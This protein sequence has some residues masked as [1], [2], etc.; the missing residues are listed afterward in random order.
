MGCIVELDRINNY[1]TG[2]EYTNTG[3]IVVPKGADPSK[4][5]NG[6]ITNSVMNKLHLIKLADDFP[7]MEKDI[8]SNR[9]KF[10]ALSFVDLCKM[11]TRAMRYD[12][13]DFLYCK[14][15]GFPVNRLITLRRYPYPCTDNIWDKESQGEPDI[16]RMVTYFDQEVNKMEELLGFGFKMKWKE[17]TAEYEQSTMQGD[18]AGLSGF[19]KKAFTVFDPN[20]YNNHLMG[21]N[22][23]M[24]DPKFDQ[25]KVYGPVDSIT[26]TNIRDVGLEFEKNFD[27]QFDYEL[28]SENGRTPE[29]AMKDILA[30]ILAC[31]FNDGK[32]WPGARYWVGDRPSQFY[33]RFQYMN[34]TDMDNILSKATNDLKSVLKTFGDK[35]SAV[36]ALKTAMQGGMA[37]AMG[38]ILDKVGRPGILTMNSLLSGEPTG[39]WHLTIGNPVN[40]IM[41]IGNLILE[42]VEV[43]FPTDALGYGDFPTKMRAKV[44]LKPAQ[45]RGRAGIEMP[46][47]MGKHRIYFAPKSVNVV[48][49]NKNASRDAFSFFGF[50]KKEVDNAIGQTYDFIADGVKSISASVVQKDKPVTRSGSSSSPDSSSATNMSG[51]ANPAFK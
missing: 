2:P 36:D 37:L 47:N 5:K 29:Y 41:C 30:N 9:D 20:L 50:D 40:P 43:S 14:N 6:Q 39:F 13:D 32:F 48:K 11:E 44:K 21:E 38:K 22:A 25:N 28:R 10:K 4:I 45:N 16:A 18:Q 27:I 17:L 26:N 3:N 1:V 35:S 34:T 31:C 42:D 49:T 23:K 46:F 24:L 7:A 8:P 19:M 51:N 15:L 33:Q 12:V